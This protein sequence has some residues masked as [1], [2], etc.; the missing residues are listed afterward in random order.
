[1]IRFMPRPLYPDVKT[2]STNWLLDW[3]YISAV[4]DVS[5]R[6]FMRLL[7]SGNSKAEKE[8]GYVAAEQGTDHICN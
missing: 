5:E 3:V 6:Y 1:M 7:R 4:L 8:A 2:P